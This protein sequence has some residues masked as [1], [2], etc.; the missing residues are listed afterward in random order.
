MRSDSTT[1]F[2]QASRHLLSRLF[3]HTFGLR[4]SSPRV[5]VLLDGLSELSIHQIT[6][7]TVL[8]FQVVHREAAC[9]H[10]CRSTLEKDRQLF[11][12]NFQDWSRRSIRGFSS[13]SPKVF[14]DAV[15]NYKPGNRTA[16]IFFDC[17]QDKHQVHLRFLCDIHFQLRYDFR[18]LQKVCEHD[19]RCLVKSPEFG[20]RKDPW[21]LTLRFLLALPR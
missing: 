16:G 14:Q 2:E 8:Q 12:H 7:N 3:V 19:S 17:C 9:Y 4:R 11:H 13:V 1:T 21:R 6:S 5:E 18:H 15:E 10:E 20:R